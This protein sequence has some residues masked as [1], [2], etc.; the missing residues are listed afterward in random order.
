MLRCVRR[1]EL[2][3]RGEFLCSVDFKNLTDSVMYAAVFAFLRLGRV[4][5]CNVKSNAEIMIDPKL[6]TAFLSEL[7]SSC[8]GR[9][10]H[11]DITV[12][13]GEIGIA[14]SG[15]GNIDKLLFYIEKFKGIY[16]FS[17][18]LKKATIRIPVKTAIAPPERVYSLWEF[19][20]DSFSDVNIFLK[21][22]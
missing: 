18:D 5:V 19:I 6:Y 16:Y 3:L 1:A 11:I 20:N 13:K 17:G 7:C 8:D 2:K 15:I 9:A 12:E 22:E 4:L 14:V 21:D 10:T